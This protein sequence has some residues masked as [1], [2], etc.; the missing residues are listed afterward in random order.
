MA[1]PQVTTTRILR[2]LLASGVHRRAERLLAR[3]HPADLGP[4]LA[5]L[6]PDEIRDVMDLL[7]RQHR[8][9]STLRQL[10]PE[11]LPQIFEAFQPANRWRAQHGSRTFHRQ[12]A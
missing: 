2:R 7:F 12:C 9:A 11:L 3:I 10:P 1:T 8:A 4:L 6:S 5:D